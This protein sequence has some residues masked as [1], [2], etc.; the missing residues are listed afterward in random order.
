MD[1]DI[2]E[3]LEKLYSFFYHPFPKGYCVK[4]NSIMVAR[5]I[6]FCRYISNNLLFQHILYA[7]FIDDELKVGQ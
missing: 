1:K 7:F 5:V 2:S 6:H 4:M 3:L